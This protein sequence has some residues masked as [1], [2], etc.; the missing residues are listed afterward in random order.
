V[1]PRYF[2]SYYS[3]V[4]LVVASSSWGIIH[5]AYSYLLVSIAFYLTQLPL[6]IC[7]KKKKRCCHDSRPV[8]VPTQEKKLWNITDT[9]KPFS[10]KYTAI[11]SCTCWQLRLRYGGSNN[12]RMLSCKIKYRFERP[13][14]GQASGSYIC[15][16]TDH[17]SVWAVPVLGGRASNTVRN[18]V[19]S[20]LK[21]LLDNTAGGAVAHPWYSVVLHLN[22]E[23]T[24][25]LALSGAT[26]PVGDR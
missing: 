24:F 10:S 4:V 2:S 3:T 18:R 22:K 16:K 13:L 9:M 17:Q 8:R 1:V 21:K 6:V 26:A 5:H 19:E 20:A 15:W 23:T 25:Q 7:T 14:A 11:N 12:A